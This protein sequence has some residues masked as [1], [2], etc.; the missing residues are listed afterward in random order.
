MSWHW[1][2]SSL[3]APSSKPGLRVAFLVKSLTTTPWITDQAHGL[4]RR[5]VEICPLAMRGAPTGDGEAWPPVCLP[6]VIDV[7]SNK[8]GR[9]MAVAREMLRAGTRRPLATA[10][11]VRRI[12]RCAGALSTSLALAATSG[13]MQLLHGHFGNYAA[14]ILPVR[15]LAGLPLVVSFYGWDASA[16]PRPDPALYEDLFRESAAVIALSR[17]MNSTLVALGCP[18]EKL[19]IVHVSVRIDELR[20]QVLRAGGGGDR[21]GTDEEGLRLLAVG[22]LVEKKGLDDALEAVALLVQHGVD[23]HFRIVGD[24][25]LRGALESQAQDLGLVSRV[26]FT[27]SLPREAVFREMARCDVFFLP[28]RVA[29]SGDREGTPTVLIEAGALGI[30]CVAT[31]HAGTPEV[32]LDE[33]TGLLAEERDVGGLAERLE[34]LAR[35]EALRAD[36][37]AAARR[38]IEAEFELESQCARL[39]SIYRRCLRFDG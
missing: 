34:R 25:P 33:Q 32:V 17:E 23:F 26:E 30:P 21:L 27:G 38:H 29:A 3:T 9:T 14:S 13:H 31:I 28:S 22:R 1:R 5:G 10:G 37:G 35:S 20:R 36:L 12:G 4:S 18:T 6:R 24:G 16:A 7:P 11:V 2:I 19:E 15:R 8:S 39:E